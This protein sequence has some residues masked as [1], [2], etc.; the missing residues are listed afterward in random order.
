[1]TD[2]FKIGIIGVGYIGNYHAANFHN[3]EQAELA[4]IADINEELLHK[5][6]TTY[7]I[8]H[9]YTDYREMLANETLDGV[10]VAT[11]DH[12]HREPALA[13]AEAGIPLL[14]EKPIA[15]TLP[16]AEAITEAVEKAAIPCMLSFGLRLHEPYAIIKQRFANGQYGIPATAYAKRA[17]KLSEARRLQG[18][19]SVNEY[20][21]VHDFD[22]L[23]W[24][25]GSEVES[26][27]TVKSG[28]RAMEELNTADHYWNL[29]RWKNGASASVL[30]SWGRVLGCP[31]IVSNEILVIGTKG[32]AQITERWAEEGGNHFL[33][34]RFAT[35]S[36]CVEPDIPVGQTEADHFI[37]IL[38]GQT[39]PIATVYDGLKTVRLV[40]AGE[41]SARTGQPVAVDL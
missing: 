2:R 24:L 4:A 37:D 29:L 26:I 9:I 23:L 17:C 11:P 12:L 13:V 35:D 1:M 39:E 5:R 14:L 34:N 22:F 6:Q 27:Y 3:L 7:H 10:V 33:K 25:F 41:E 32:S 40:L 15:T 16:D 36:T 20:L 28:F 30:A 8:P 38:S 31:V 21:A 19:C 18:R